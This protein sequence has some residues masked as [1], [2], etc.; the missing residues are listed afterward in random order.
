M[1]SVIINLKYL[2]FRSLYLL[3]REA[4]WKRSSSSMEEEEGGERGGAVGEKGEKKN[5]YCS[6]SL[7]CILFFKSNQGKHKGV[8]LFHFSL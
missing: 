8:F 6:T 5:L 7:I 2:I 4:E 3:P 1:K